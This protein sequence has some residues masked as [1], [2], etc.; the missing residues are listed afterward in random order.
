MRLWLDDRFA[1]AWQV[2]DPFAAVADI[3]GKIYRQK[4]GRTTLS[5]EL[6][7]RGYFLKLHRGI[8]WGEIFKNLL[9]G[10]APVLGA[11]NEFEAA[12]KLTALGVDTLTPVAFGER[13]ANPAARYSFLITEDLSGTVDLEALCATWPQQ[14]PARALKQA[15]LRRVANV[16]R[17]MHGNGINHRDYYLCHFLL[18]PATVGEPPLESD[19]RCY[20]IDLHRAQMRAATPQ[21]WRIK[22]LAGLFFSAMDIGL[23]RRD[24]LRFI[25]LYSG[26]SWR[27]SLQRDAKLWRAVAARAAAMYR[28]DHQA[29]PPLALRPEALV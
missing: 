19:L 9:Q 29:E 1:A 26:M 4:E 8:G 7:G 3:H 5:F 28:R 27:E 6:A 20:L 13:G 15:L 11:A 24:L 16:S 18:D 10:R 25:E 14:P 21:R 2:S 17:V 12:R 23:T 22:D